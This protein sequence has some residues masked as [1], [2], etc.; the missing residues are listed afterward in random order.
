MRERAC[1]YY[2]KGTKATVDHHNPSFNA[3]CMRIPLKI[4]ALMQ[5]FPEYIVRSIVRQRQFL[6]RGHR[7]CFDS[8]SG[9]R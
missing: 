5:T 3:F 6:K 8:Q 1:H 7:Y 2:S 4:V 9:E